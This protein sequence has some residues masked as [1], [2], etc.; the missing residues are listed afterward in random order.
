MVTQSLSSLLDGRHNRLVFSTIKDLSRRSKDW[1]EAP[2]YIYAASLDAPEKL[3]EGHEVVK[4]LHQL[5]VDVKKVSV[6]VDAEISNRLAS[7][8]I[9]HL[10]K[11]AQDSRATLNNINSILGNY[12]RGLN[13][14]LIQQ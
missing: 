10:E 12:R 8:D 11:V 9:E 14:P 1:A 13:S 6:L 2:W 3:H 7:D 5:A 4:T